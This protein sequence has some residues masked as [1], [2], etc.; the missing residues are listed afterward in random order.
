M[1]EPVRIID[2]ARRLIEESGLDIDVVY[3]GLRQGEKLDEVLFSSVERGVPSEHPLITRVEV[4]PLSPSQLAGASDEPQA[5]PQRVGTLPREGL[6]SPRADV[7]YR[8][9]LSRMSQWEGM[10]G[11]EMT[12]LG[13]QAVTDANKEGLISPQP[14]SDTAFPISTAAPALEDVT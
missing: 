13:K 1:G 6:R 12:G 11:R 14:P 2:V 3:T 7:E 8:D 9:A 5:N 10:P 4:P